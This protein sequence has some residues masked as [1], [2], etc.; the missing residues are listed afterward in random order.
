MRR[1]PLPLVLLP[2]LSVCFDLA[3]APSS[4]IAASCSRAQS[5]SVK[6]VVGTLRP[7]VESVIE[8]GEARIFWMS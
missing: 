5:I 1:F 6:A 7:V 3:D 2:V 4:A 8:V